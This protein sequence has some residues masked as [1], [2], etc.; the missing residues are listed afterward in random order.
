MLSKDAT[1]ADLLNTYRAGEYE[2]LINNLCDR[3]PAIAST[4]IIQAILE[5]ELAMDDGKRI[6]NWL[7]QHFLMNRPI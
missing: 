1:F 5:G 6:A 4:F 7:M 2:D 3:H